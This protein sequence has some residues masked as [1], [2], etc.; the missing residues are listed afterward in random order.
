MIDHVSSAKP[1]DT[2]SNSSARRRVTHSGG[3]TDEQDNYHTHH[4]YADIP[5][6]STIRNET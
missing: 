6:F 5:L 2:T 1:D 4:P 3:V